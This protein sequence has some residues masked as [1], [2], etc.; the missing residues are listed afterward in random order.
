MRQ[1]WRLLFQNQDRGKHTVLIGTWT[2]NPASSM[3]SGLPCTRSPCLRGLLSS[4]LDPLL[5]VRARGASACGIFLMILWISIQYYWHSPQ[6][7]KITG[8]FWFVAYFGGCAF[9]LVSA[10]VD[11]GRRVLEILSSLLSNHESLCDK[12][13]FGHTLDFVFAP[14]MHLSTWFSVYLE[15]VSSLEKLSPLEFS[16]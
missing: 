3:A 2:W 4:E 9:S 11:A 16:S 5:S 1:D 6:L 15:A 10:F 13:L 8:V 7:S 12:L 14:R